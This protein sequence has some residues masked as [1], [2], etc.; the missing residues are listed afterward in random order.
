MAALFAEIVSAATRLMTD[1]FGCGELAV[2]FCADVRSSE[3]FA[4]AAITWCSVSLQ[5]VRVPSC[6]GNSDSLTLL[7]QARLSSAP[8]W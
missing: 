8:S 6:L 1:V 5:R 3:R 2:N 4:L 7:A